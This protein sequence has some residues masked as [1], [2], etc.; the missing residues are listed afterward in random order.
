MKVFLLF[1][2]ASFILGTLVD[3]ATLLQRCLLMAGIVVAVTTAYFLFEQ[4][5]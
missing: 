1:L 4:L 2:M 3:R 5:V